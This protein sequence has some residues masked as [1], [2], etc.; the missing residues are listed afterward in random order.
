M[1]S[2]PRIRYLHM[3]FSPGT[4]LPSVTELWTRLRTSFHRLPRVV[5]VILGLQVAAYL[6]I[7]VAGTSDF[8]IRLTGVIGLTPELFFKGWVWQGFTYGFF[9]LR[10]DLFPFLVDI[11]LVWSLGGLF[12]GRWRST[13]FLFFYLVSGL[14]GAV[15]HSA[16]AIPFPGQF[17]HPVMGAAG[18]VY[19][20]LVAYRLVFGE[21]LVTMFG[22]N[23]FKGK[24][25][26]YALVGLSVLFF[27]FGVNRNFAVEMGGVLAGWLMVTGRWR[28]NKMNNWVRTLQRGKGPYSR[29]ASR[30]D[31]H[32]V[33]GGRKN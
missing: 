28:P 19:A 2:P 13:H 7:L 17:A 8:G 23:P 25:L 20:L 33:D 24:W 27:L 29:K 10:Q 3:G 5:Q 15:L 4:Q 26:F 32:V 30:R 9:H 14:V 18:S 1:N 16:L 22:G 21:Q 6:L 31:F 11:A 12:A